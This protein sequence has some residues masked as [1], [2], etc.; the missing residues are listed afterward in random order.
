[1]SKPACEVLH[2]RAWG[3]GPAAGGSRGGER[4]LCCGGVQSSDSEGEGEGMDDDAMERLNG[5]LA[6]AVR[7]ASQS[8]PNS[9]ERRQQMLNFKLRR[10]HSSAALAGTGG[11][12]NST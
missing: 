10:A 2:P 4:C 9:S 1:M 3:C 12:G 11:S 7:A 8:K 6:A 5:G